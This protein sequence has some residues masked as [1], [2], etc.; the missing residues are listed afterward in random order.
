MPRRPRPNLS[1]GADHAADEDPCAKPASPSTLAA[2]TKI[3]TSIARCAPL[4]L[5]L[6]LQPK[7]PQQVSAVGVGGCK[8]FNLTSSIDSTLTIRHLSTYFDT[9]ECL[10]ATVST[11]DDLSDMWS[12]MCQADIRGGG[13]TN[14]TLIPESSCIPHTL[15]P[16]ETGTFRMEYA[17]CSDNC[18][19]ACNCGPTMELPLGRLDEHYLYM[20]ELC[21]ADGTCVEDV[22][23]D[24]IGIGRLLTNSSMPSFTPSAGPSTFSLSAAPSVSSSP[25]RAPS[26]ELG[27]SAPSADPCLVC[28]RQLLRMP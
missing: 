4:G 7:S 2:S 10:R 14:I 27:S 1:R 26:A 17:S 5:L 3:M 11:Y 21:D 9:T 12:T 25:S 15:L 28:H 13:G 18:T 6:L 20:D 19:S 24:V 16:G 22:V 23:V 8:T